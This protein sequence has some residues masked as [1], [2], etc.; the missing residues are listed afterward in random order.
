M[1]EGNSRLAEDPIA[2]VPV[3]PP[4]CQ[5]PACLQEGERGT[6]PIRGGSSGFQPQNVALAEYC[7]PEPFKSRVAGSLITPPTDI[8][9]TG[10]SFRTRDTAIA[11]HTNFAELTFYLLFRKKS[12]QHFLKSKGPMNQMP[13]HMLIQPLLSLEPGDSGSKNSE[14]HGVQTP[15]SMATPQGHRIFFLSPRVTAMR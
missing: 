1:L 8:L 3:V 2:S 9:L 7:G 12:F 14:C 10:S 6:T 4:C 15:G 5:H 11:K 13:I